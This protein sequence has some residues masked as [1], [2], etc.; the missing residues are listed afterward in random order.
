MFTIISW[1]SYVTAIG[2]ILCL[3]YL[4]LGFRFYSTEIKQILFGK[5]KIVFPFFGN[6]KSKKSLQTIITDKS[7]DSN[8]SESFSESFATLDEVKELSVRIID[9][10]EESAGRNLSQQEYKN[11]LKLI[12]EEYPYVKISSLQ[13]TING[14]IVS[15][16]QK[17]TSLALTLKQAE[18]L[19]NETF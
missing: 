5:R 12:L 2:I 9:A 1:S 17:H 6:K 7:F 3:W 18:D 15:E 4:F 16:S 11:F 19:W 10:T 14:L 13:G 8:L